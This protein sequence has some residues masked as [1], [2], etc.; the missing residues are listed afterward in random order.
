MAGGWGNLRIRDEP[1]FL[2]LDGVIVAMASITFTV[3]QPGFMFLLMR[4]VK[5]SRS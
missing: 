3:T 1:V 4:K 2:A 5:K